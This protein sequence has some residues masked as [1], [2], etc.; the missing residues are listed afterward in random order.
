M[1]ENKKHSDPGRIYDEYQRGVSYKS[2]IG[3]K[4]LYEQAKVNER[5][6]I[7]DQW[8]GANCG[9]DRPL[10]RHN[11]IKRI[12][13]YKMAVV[14]SNPVA[15]N[16]TAEGVPNTLQL[17]ERI[18]PIRDRY[19]TGTYGGDY[20]DDQEVPTDQE[21][22]I[23]MAAMSDYFRVTAER[24]NFEGIRELALRN[25]YISGTGVVYTWWDDTI[26]TG[27]YADEGKKTPIRGDISC[28]V[29]DIENVYF[30][31]PVMDDVQKQPYILI[32]Q[33]KSVS[34]LRYE[35]KKNRRPTDEIARIV[36]D[37]DTGN[38]GGD[39]SDSEPIDSKKATV[40]TKFWKEWDEEGNGYTI[41][42]VRVCRGVTIR[43]EWDLKIR[44]YPIAK[45]S[46][47]RRRNCAYG[48]SE[49]T[50]LVPN[51]IAINRMITASVWAV[52]M[53]GMPIMVVNG[54]LVPGA[55]TNDPGQVIRVFGGQEDVER[56][57]RYVNPPNF[58]PKFDD[59]VASLIQ[60]TMVQEGANE[61]ALGDIRPDN[62]SAIIAVREAATMPMQMVQ[63]RYYSFC[64]E[65][66]RIW[67]EY[68]VMQYG[69][70]MLK[71]DDE[72]GTWYLPFDG[73]R[74][75]DLVISTRVDVGAS[76]LWSESQSIRTLDNLFDRQVIDVLQYL[77]R[78]PKGTVPNLN[79]LIRE[80]QAANAAVS[81]QPVQTVPA[82]ENADEGIS[83][84]AGAL[85]EQDITSMLSPEYQQ[86]FSAMPQQARTALLKGIYSSQANVPET[87]PTGTI[88]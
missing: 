55:V 51:Q 16:Y 53:M 54:D 34:E 64:E 13:N 40:I 25:A 20:Y 66:A 4:G 11:V 80:L 44:L 63:N 22:N 38:G 81:Q 87:M 71:I 78:L 86:I 42:A 28:E 10:V 57:I 41:K 74:Y 58:S 39:G 70:R 83:Q 76:T 47:E 72:N 23:V 61:A 62:T 29:L 12:G 60:N 24:V 88:I 32:V 84:N 69:K 33:R 73:D 36:P 43:K 7:G 46:W 2:A 45:Y 1:E 9:S 26:K 77:T 6:F 17:K 14:G 21:I 8:H 15:V 65:I 37:S 35:A 18:K 3:R 5:F 50:Y 75:K 56:A 59:N 82:A 48:E 27:L 79:G 19:A 49:I 30:G 68:W 85:N 31:D 67:A 52:M